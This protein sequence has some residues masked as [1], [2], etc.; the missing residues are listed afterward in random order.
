MNRENWFLIAPIDQNAN[1]LASLDIKKEVMI[2]NYRQIISQVAQEQFLPTLIFV[3]VMKMALR[4]GP[5]QRLAV[6]ANANSN[7]MPVARIT[8]QQILVIAR[9][10]K[11][12]E[13]LPD[14]LLASGLLLQLCVLAE[15]HLR[16]EKLLIMFGLG[17][18]QQEVELRYLALLQE[19]VLE[20][21]FGHRMMNKS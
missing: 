2:A 4:V 15:M 14:N 1:I 3:E 6:L 13:A 10:L 21:E 17:P 8:A 18:V 9:W 12:A 5:M 19:I 20:S 7:A 11:V 16:S